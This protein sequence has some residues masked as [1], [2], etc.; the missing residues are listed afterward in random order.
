MPELE[1]VDHSSDPAGWAKELGVSVEA[2]ELVLDS[3]F[4]DLHL[5]LDVP[6]RVVGWSSTR[7]HKTNKR[8]PL[9]WGQTDLPRLIEAGFT[10]VVYDVATNPVRPPGNRQRATLRNL[11]RICDTIVEHSEHLALVTSRSAYDRA[12]ADGKLAIW[13]ALQGGNAFAHDLSVLDGEIGQLLHRITL[14]HLTSSRLGGTSSPAG[15]DRGVGALGR[16]CIERCNA[17]RVFV[18][19]A[20][21]G[22]KTFWDALD[23]HSSEVAP[24]VSHT[25]VC[26]VRDHWRNL[27]DDQIRAIVDR[28][29]LVGI[30]YQSNFLEPTLLY[31]K[32]ASIVD[33]LA[34]V[35]GLVGEDYAAIGTDYDGAIVP[36]SD[37][38][39]VT[40][41]PKLVQDMLDRGWSAD[42]IRK[43][44]GGNY[45]RVVGEM[46]P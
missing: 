10:G 29:G 27:D 33:H 25:G 20:H 43:I 11:D 13:L 23:A 18:D 16:E 7:R 38:A 35:I 45:L 6:V 17:N 36:P 12:R 26:G 32:R 5:D 44:L 37:L 8:P 3:D 4:V 46:R 9:L 41:H 31:A 24:I 34:Y 42:R 2:V 30:M 21:A 1:I 28:G 15:M 40:H 14:V 22:K 19:L 39:D